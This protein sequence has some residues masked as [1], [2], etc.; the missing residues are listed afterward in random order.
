MSPADLR[1]KGDIAPNTM[2]RMRKDKEV[3]IQVLER[4]CKVLNIDFGEIIEYM[5]NKSIDDKH[6]D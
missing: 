3:S 2:T 1:K 4:I 6:R 5:P